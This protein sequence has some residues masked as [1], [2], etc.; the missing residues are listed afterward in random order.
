MSHWKLQERESVDPNLS[1]L[2]VRQEKVLA[3]LNKNKW[4]N[5]YSSLLSKYEKYGKLTE[6]Q[7]AAVENSIPK[8]L[9][10]EKK[11]AAIQK[12]EDDRFPNREAVPSD[13]IQVTGEVQSLKLKETHYGP[14]FKMLVLDDRGFKVYGSVPSAVE[15]EFAF[16]WVKVGKGMRVT[17]TATTKPSEEDEHFGFYSRPANAKVINDLNV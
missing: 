16:T 3:H 8:D 5:F 12:E 11:R 17:F 6:G 9:E 4:N 13:R 14:T 15:E 2:E 7:I 10:R 1:Y